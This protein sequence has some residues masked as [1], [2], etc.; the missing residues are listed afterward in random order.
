MMEVLVLP[1]S[2]SCNRRVSFDSLKKIVSLHLYPSYELG[3]TG[4][5]GG[6]EANQKVRG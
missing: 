5:G 1:P 4:K 3:N 2:E 6:V